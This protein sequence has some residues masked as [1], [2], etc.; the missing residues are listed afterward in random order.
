MVTE[1]L[2]NEMKSSSDEYSDEEFDDVDRDEKMQLQPDSPTHK[3]NLKEDNSP[4]L[5]KKSKE[6]KY[7]HDLEESSNLKEKQ[8]L[9]DP[10]KEFYELKET[11]R[12]EQIEE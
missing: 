7:Y 11:M 1:T 3:F 6:S 2:K 4:K 8:S 5:F 12:K 9:N 10:L